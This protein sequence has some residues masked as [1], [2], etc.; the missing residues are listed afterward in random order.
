[1]R[2]GVS[3]ETSCRVSSSRCVPSAFARRACTG[4]RQASCTCAL[5]AQWYTIEGRADSIAARTA[6]TVEQVHGRPVDAGARCAVL[7]A[8]PR[9]RQHREP[10]G[11]QPIEQMTAREPR[12]AGDERKTRHRHSGTVA[13]LVLV[14]LLEGGV[15]VLDGPPPRLVVEIPPHGLGEPLLEVGPWTPAERRDLRRVERVP[16]IVPRPIRHGSDERRGLAEEVED[17]VRRDR[18]S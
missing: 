9:P 6:G 18:R 5:P 17:P 4:D 1:M 11:G 3:G 14:V 13:V 7:S 12:G 8:G 15:L 10:F 2:T 16:A